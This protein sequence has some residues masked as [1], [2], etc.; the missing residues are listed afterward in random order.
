MG[1]VTKGAQLRSWMDYYLDRALH[2]LVLDIT[3]SH[4]RTE[5]PGG[6]DLEINTYTLSVNMALGVV[7]RQFIHLFRHIRYH[8]SL[9]L[10]F[11][12]TLSLERHQ[13]RTCSRGGLYW[14]LLITLKILQLFKNVDSAEEHPEICKRPFQVQ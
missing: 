14:Q 1:V 11:A 2:D 8:I 10:S 4:L 6:A 9:V 7:E 13:A 5:D 12:L 3:R